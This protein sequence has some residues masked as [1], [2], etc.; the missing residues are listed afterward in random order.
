MNIYLAGGM[1][2]DWRTGITLTVPRHTYY[3]PATHGLKDWTEYSPWDFSAIDH[4]DWLFGYFEKDNPSGF[5]LCCEIGYAKGKG[6]RVLFVNEHEDNWDKN[7]YLKL[8][9]FCSDVYYANLLDGVNFLT[10]LQYIQT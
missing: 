10:A 8:I 4:C 7:K 1:R 9:R 2:A 5:G 3:S 6:K